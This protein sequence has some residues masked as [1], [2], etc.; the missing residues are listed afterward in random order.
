MVYGKRD[1]EIWGCYALMDGAYGVVIRLR[2]ELKHI[3][4]GNVAC[5]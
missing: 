2:E 3:D 1:G 4:Q 5:Y